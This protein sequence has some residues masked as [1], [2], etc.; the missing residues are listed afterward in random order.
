MLRDSCVL[1]VLRL[2]VGMHQ[3]HAGWVSR[4]RPEEVLDAQH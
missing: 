1:G 3:V 2:H 4:E